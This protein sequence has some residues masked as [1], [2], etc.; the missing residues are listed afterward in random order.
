MSRSIMH[1]TC[2]E[3]VRA[4]EL[5]MRSLFIGIRRLIIKLNEVDFVGLRGAKTLDCIGTHLGCESPLTFPVES[6]LRT[7]AQSV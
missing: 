2:C 4:G 1:G 7:G 6:L 3:I 5:E